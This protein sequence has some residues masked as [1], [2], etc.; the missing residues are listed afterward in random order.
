LPNRILRDWT[1]S[2]R[3]DLLTAE[4][5]RFFTRLI[6]KVDDFGRFYAEPRRLR[7]ACFPL[8]DSIRDADISRWLAECEK[9]GVVCCYEAT[10]CRYVC[11]LRFNQRLRAM[12][13]RF[14]RPPDDLTVT[15]QSD[16]RQMTAAFVSDS[17]SDSQQGKRGCKGERGLF[18]APGI[19]AVKLQCAK[20]GL[21]ESEASH[22][23]DYYESNGWRVGKNPMRSWTGA[24]NNW[25]RNYDERKYS[26]TPRHGNQPN[27]RNAGVCIGP[28]DYAAAFARKRAETERKAA[29]LAGPL[30][31]DK[32]S[33]PATNGS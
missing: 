2:G 4:G 26:T 15:C 25:K 14:P 13:E 11:V 22:F 27:P 17:V 30:V 21:P 7:S 32:S 1:D 23:L 10:G 29:G 28:T 19:E 8:K 20:I 24:L 6:M 33:P 18:E 5:E 3:I 31:A 16:D 12:K 9:A